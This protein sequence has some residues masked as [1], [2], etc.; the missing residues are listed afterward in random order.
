MPTQNVWHVSTLAPA[1]GP[2][3]LIAPAA[4][5]EAVLAE[6]RRLVT[7]RFEKAKRLAAEAVG[8]FPDHEKIHSAHQ[9][10]NSP[11]GPIGSAP[12]EPPTDQELEWLSGAP[13][14]LG[15][16]WVAVSGSE[17]LA[18][19]EDLDAVMRALGSEHSDRRALVHYLE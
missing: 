9:V 2:A 1:A 17:L 10:L 8:R 3:R 19:D 15:G 11:K 13:E 5:P 7:D 6:I 16:Q 14:S 18:A 4:R 12:S